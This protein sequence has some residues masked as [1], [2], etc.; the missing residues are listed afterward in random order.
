[1][2]ARSK[3]TCPTRCRNV[4]RLH[5]VRILT[6]RL[7][8][9][10]KLVRRSPPGKCGSFHLFRFRTCRCRTGCSRPA[11]R[12]DISS[13]RQGMPLQG[14]S[15]CR[16]PAFHLHTAGR[17]RRSMPPDSASSRPRRRSSCCRFGC[18][19]RWGCSGR[20]GRSTE[21][22]SIFPRQPHRCFPNNAAPWDAD[23]PVRGFRRSTPGRL[24]N[25]RLGGTL[26][27]EG[28]GIRSGRQPGSRSPP[29]ACSTPEPR[30]AADRRPLREP[31][32][33]RQARRTR[34]RRRPPAVPKRTRPSGEG[35]KAMPPPQCGRSARR[36]RIRPAHVGRA[37]WRTA[38]AT[39]KRGF[40]PGSAEGDKYNWP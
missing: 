8:C 18:R 21:P 10:R 9:R 13:D 1:M 17:S 38:S 31:R 11:T 32:I 36:R 3:R 34:R 33:G 37:V 27:W 16:I 7:Q 22:S 40:M 24:R 23:N 28:P 30:A 15:G 14:R 4:Q 39:A 26:H 19:I 12:R 20:T 25:P 5:T 2:M 29:S 35:R 6:R